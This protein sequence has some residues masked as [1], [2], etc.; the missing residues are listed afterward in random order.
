MYDPATSIIPGLN[1]SGRGSW[2][3]VL[4]MSPLVWLKPKAAKGWDNKSTMKSFMWSCSFLHR[5]IILALQQ[6]SGIL[7]QTTYEIP[8]EYHFSPLSLESIIHINF[9]PLAALLV[10][11]TA[12]LSLQELKSKKC[13]GHQVGEHSGLHAAMLWFLSQSCFL[14]TD[15]CNVLKLFFKKNEVLHQHHQRC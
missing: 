7:H 5:L 13:V 14:L 11:W 3:P 12:T 2:L 6:S 10:Y 9:L 8:K 15:I 1:W 4:D